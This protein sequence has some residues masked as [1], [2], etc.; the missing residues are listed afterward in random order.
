MEK[1]ELQKN[2]ALYHSK[3]PQ[4][5]QDF[6]SKMEW[7]ETLQKIT[8]KYDLNATQQE[9]LGTETTLVLL[10]MVHPVEYEENLAKELN[11]PKNY[12][13]SIMQELENSILSE[14]RPL[15]IDAYNTNKKNESASPEE[16]PAGDA[17]VQKLDVRFLK[18][19]KEI[20][21]VV[22]KSNYQSALYA[23]AQAHKLSVTQMGVLDN[24]TTDLIIGTIHP[25][26]FKDALTKS[27]SLPEEETVKLVDEVNTQVFK[28]IRQELVSISSSNKTGESEKAELDNDM[29]TLKSHGIEILPVRT[30]EGSQGP[31][32]SNGINTQKINITPPQPVKIQEDLSAI[33]KE[34][35]LQAGKVEIKAPEIKIPPTLVPNV[36]PILAQKMSAPVQTP[37]TKTQYGL[38]NAPKSALE[39]VT[40]ISTPKTSTTYKPGQDP[41]RVMP[42]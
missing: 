16:K 27:L 11:L 7:L 2:I 24:V 1:E 32:T 30:D 29:D 38:N 31:S 42:E 5:A 23:I 40:P 14:N 4:K 9:T 15:L 22:E 20:R 18:L 19:P 3:L 33:S 39:T 13:D 6:F 35:T 12:L 28:K 41:Y 21:E 17:I 26:Q 36:H 25:D 37:V 34:K 10:G 8:K